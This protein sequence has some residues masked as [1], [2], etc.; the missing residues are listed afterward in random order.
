MP[1]WRAA[2]PGKAGAPSG[3]SNDACAAPSG[4]PVGGDTP[5]RTPHSGAPSAPGH[6][7]PAAPS[8]PRARPARPGT[9]ALA[10][11]LF[12]RP[13]LNGSARRARCGGAGAPPK[14]GGA[15]P[16]TSTGPAV[17]C[18]GSLPARVGDASAPRHAP[19]A[20]PAM[21][22]GA[23]LAREAARTLGGDAA[24]GRQAAPARRESTTLT[25]R[26]GGGGAPAGA[27][28]R[29]RPGDAPRAP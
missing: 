10:L 22:S 1:L 21:S 23:V 14:P 12:S 18:S 15:Q 27:R 20:Q 17:G 5:M 13:A 24:A 4:A 28:P 6:Q 16:A 11:P 25:R 9:F 29:D 3:V 7:A 8:T 26:A 19:L 2:R